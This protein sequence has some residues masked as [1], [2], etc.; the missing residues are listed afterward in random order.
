[1]PR[2]RVRLLEQGKDSFVPTQLSPHNNSTIAEAVKR[3]A[4]QRGG[5]IQI[6][7]RSSSVGRLL[8][9]KLRALG[10]YGVL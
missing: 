10:H 7:Q 5:R 2:R 4:Q 6:W 9:A 8:R 1:M 3:K